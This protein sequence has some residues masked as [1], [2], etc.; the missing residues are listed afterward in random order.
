MFMYNRNN[1]IGQDAL[2]HHSLSDSTGIFFIFKKKNTCKTDLWFV[3]TVSY[4]NISPS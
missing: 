1:R 4:L 2:G 3:I